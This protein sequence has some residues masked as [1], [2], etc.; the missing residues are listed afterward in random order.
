MWELNKLLCKKQLHWV[1]LRP[2]YVQHALLTAV[3]SFQP[4]LCFFKFHFIFN[5]CCHIIFLFLCLSYISYHTILR[6][7]LHS[8]TWQYSFLFK[9]QTQFLYIYIFLYSLVHQR[10]LRL[11]LNFVMVNS[12]AMNMEN[13]DAT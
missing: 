2:F 10:T 13:T 5:R 12:T 1:P 3:P 9:S 6:V 7:H 8:H 11:F 4:I